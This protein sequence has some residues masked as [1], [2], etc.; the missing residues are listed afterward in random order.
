LL[1]RAGLVRVCGVESKHSV[2]R[3][4]IRYSLSAQ[5]HDRL[6]KQYG[7]LAALLLDEVA[8]TLG[9][10]QA[11]ELLRR[12]GRR[13]AAAAPLD[14]DVGTALRLKHLKFLSSRGYQ[15]SWERHGGQYE[16]V[17]HDCPYREV[18]QAQPLVCE[19][20]RALI[21][22]LLGRPFAMTTCI[23]AREAECH[24]AIEN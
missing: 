13:V 24:F 9:S 8:R 6:P 22:A 2:G 23:A 1:E 11:R 12:A 7:P 15:A 4:K 18:A 17:V 21:G 19:L 3:P 14:R 10:R 5:A 16:L 20:D